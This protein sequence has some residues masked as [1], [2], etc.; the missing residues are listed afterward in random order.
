MTNPSIKN[1]SRQWSPS[2]EASFRAGL[3]SDRNSKLNRI[4]RGRSALLGSGSIGSLVFVRYT[5]PRNKAAFTSP[6]VERIPR[7]LTAAS[8]SPV[9]SNPTAASNSAESLAPAKESTGARYRPAGSY[10][11]P[12]CACAICMVSIT[13]RVNEYYICG[14]LRSISMG[15]S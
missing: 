6:C 1:Q 8:V 11:A 5:P 12:S 2:T 4:H 15:I 3:Q 9:H 13:A 10:P 14:D 7:F